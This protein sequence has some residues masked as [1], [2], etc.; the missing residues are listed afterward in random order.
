MYFYCIKIFIFMK[1]YHE[2]SKEIHICDYIYVYIYYINF[3]ITK[4]KN[5]YNKL[6]EK[7]S[8]ISA[9]SQLFS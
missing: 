7:T 8:F 9:V 1:V 3:A 5:R 6:R 2:N 4:D